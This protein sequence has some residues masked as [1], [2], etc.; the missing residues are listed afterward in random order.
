MRER[1]AVPVAGVL[2][3]VGAGPDG[4]H[5]VQCGIAELSRFT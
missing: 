4:V 5:Y 2:L 1:A 3:G